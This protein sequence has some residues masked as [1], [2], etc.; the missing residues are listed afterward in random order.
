M[1]WA[2]EADILAERRRTLRRSEG[3]ASDMRPELF[4][5]PF[6]DF[7]VPGGI[8][9][10][11]FGTLVLAGVLVGLWVLR[12]GAR[13]AGLDPE[14]AVDTAIWMVLAGLVGGRTFYC[15]QFW[16][17]FAADPWLGPLKIWNGG[18][19]L[20]GAMIAS[21][22]FLV[23]L[24]RASGR[25][26]LPYLDAMAPAAA[27]GMVLGRIGCLLNGCCWGK[28]CSPDFLLGVRYP[29]ESLAA[30]ELG[31]YGDGASVHPTQVYD[32]VNAAITLWILW[33]MNGHQLS[34]GMTSGALACLYGFSRF[35]LE[36]LR[37]DHR[38]LPGGITISQ[39]I[40]AALFLV[41][42]VLILRAT[43]WTR[44]AAPLPVS[45]EGIAPMGGGRGGA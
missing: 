19:V 7:L 41:G 35:S 18:L 9:I 21:V 16:E 39:W 24:R 34:P 29:A 31:A 13:R 27:A 43:A 15:I 2:P 40:S 5:V 20:Y 11:G 36:A 42:V 30:L 32:A 22:V 44:P 1:A 12:R 37:G 33:R 10:H 23:A 3:K 28:A 38:H 45:Q 8:P 26:L 4:R 25:H 6:T 14:F 17:Q